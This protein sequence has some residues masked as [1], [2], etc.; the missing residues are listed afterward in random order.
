[1]IYIEVIEKNQSVQV[2]TR[3]R[4]SVLRMIWQINYNVAKKHLL[5]KAFF[6]PILILDLK[7]SNWEI[8]PSCRV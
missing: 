4:Y 6:E 3:A 1:M 7:N 2:D 5:L 8:S